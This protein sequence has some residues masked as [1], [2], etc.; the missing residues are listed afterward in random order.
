MPQGWLVT[1]LWHG[2]MSS[3]EALSGDAWNQSLDRQQLP[4]TSFPEAP[5]D[6]A[7]YC[8]RLLNFGPSPRRAWP[9]PFAPFFPRGTRIR[10]L[11]LCAV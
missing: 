1:C 11:S 10:F 2:M 3:D 8:S 4:F 5:S 9:K 6:P 7:L